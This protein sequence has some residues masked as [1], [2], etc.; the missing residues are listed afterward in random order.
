MNE[1][2]IRDARYIVQSDKKE[3]CRCSSR[4][5]THYV[6]LLSFSNVIASSVL[7]DLI[8]TCPRIRSRLKMS[9]VDH[10]GLPL[11]IAYLV[12]I[13]AV[14]QNYI[15]KISFVIVLLEASSLIKSSKAVWIWINSSVGEAKTYF[16]E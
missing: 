6:T 7:A 1:A 15:R 5:S 13:Q 3:N 4:Y 2:N 8:R 16:E 10:D 14:N 9:S 11:K 12:L